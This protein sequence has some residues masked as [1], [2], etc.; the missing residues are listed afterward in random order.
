MT[1]SSLVISRLLNKNDNSVTLKLLN[2]LI[3]AIC[4][5]EHELAANTAGALAQLKAK[6]DNVELNSSNF[7]VQQKAPNT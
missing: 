2:K 1:T 6:T 7:S 3:N 4:D 5:G